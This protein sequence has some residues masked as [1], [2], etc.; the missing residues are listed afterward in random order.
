MIVKKTQYVIDRDTNQ[1]EKLPLNDQMFKPQIPSGSVHVDSY[2]IG[3]QVIDQWFIPAGIDPVHKEVE[4]L[5]D[6]TSGTCWPFRSIAINSTDNQVLVITNFV[7]FLPYIPSGT[8]ELPALCNHTN[9]V[10]VERGASKIA[11]KLP[12]SLWF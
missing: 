4:A 3:S 1:C 9:T 8:F 6:V 12:K 7:D 10:E 11:K 5:F 2:T